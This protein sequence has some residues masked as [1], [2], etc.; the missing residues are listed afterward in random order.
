MGSEKMRIAV[1]GLRGFPGVQGGIEKH[2]QDLY[3]RLAKDDYNITILARK[4]YVENNPYT[5]QGVRVIPLVSPKKKN[6]EA[7][8]HTFTGLLWLAK[9]RRDFDIIHLHGIGPSLLTPLARWLGF[10]VVMTNHGPDYD[11]QKWGFVAKTILRLGERLSARYAHQVIAVSKHIK[12][13]LRTTYGINAR[14]IPNG[15]NIPEELNSTDAL[16]YFGLEP[17][18]YIL[19]VGRLVPEKGFHDL[20]AAFTDS[21][22]SDWKLVIVGQADHQDSYSRSLIMQAEQIDGVVM[23]GFQKG[24]ALAELYTNAGLFVLPSYHEGLPIVALEAMSY[25]LPTLLSDIPANREVAHPEELFPVGNKVVLS[26]K[27]H[28]VITTPSA[29]S[30]PH[31]LKAKQSRL[32]SEFNWNI[33]AQ[34]TTDIYRAALTDPPA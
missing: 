25:N 18:R 20:L 21:N 19:A 16:K 28:H 12:N 33:I 1:L 14:Y 4:G 9:H 7:I 31:I 34:Q 22:V 11:R 24:K 23:T 29:I 17:K 30:P 10:R 15:V 3:P 26:Q 32:K 27:I 5:Y 2:C 13:Q 8:I 6:L